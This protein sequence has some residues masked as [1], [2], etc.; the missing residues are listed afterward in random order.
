[1]N[2]LKLDKKSPRAR[3]SGMLS[4][5]IR[6]DGSHSQTAAG[7]EKAGTARID[8]VEIPAMRETGYRQL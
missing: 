2:Y 1:M 7:Y 8:S 5:G 3:H 6:V 4:A